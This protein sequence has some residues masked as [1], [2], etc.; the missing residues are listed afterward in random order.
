MNDFNHD[1]TASAEACSVARL[2]GYPNGFESRLVEQG[3]VPASVRQKV[4]LATAFVDAKYHC[5]DKQPFI[6]EVGDPES[7]SF[8]EK[9]SSVLHRVRKKC[10]RP[11]ARRNQRK[12]NGRRKPEPCHGTS[13]IL[14]YHWM[15]SKF[16]KAHVVVLAMNAT[17]ASRHS[18]ARPPGQSRE[19]RPDPGG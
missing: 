5:P 16:V 6:A 9:Y 11:E 14:Q 4:D 15:I 3:Y 17:F 2:T 18:R 12:N 8:K 13:V 19:I 7:D 1:T 10:G